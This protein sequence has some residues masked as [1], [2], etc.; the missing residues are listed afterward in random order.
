VWEPAPQHEQP[1]WQET[2]ALHASVG[3]SS[4]EV[5]HKDRRPSGSDEVGRLASQLRSLFCAGESSGM[6]RRDMVR[7]W[8]PAFGALGP[9]DAARTMADY[10]RWLQDVATKGFADELVVA[11][12][13]IFWRIKIVVVSFTRRRNVP[14]WRISEYQPPGEPLP[15][16]R[17]VFL[18]NGDLHY[19]WL[20]FDVRK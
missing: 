11:S 3:T 8:F 12:T 17:I 15:M 4:P 19:V 14:L 20:S 7:R 13:A 1:Q 18:G 6:R 16:S 5:F 9:S 2:F 10:R